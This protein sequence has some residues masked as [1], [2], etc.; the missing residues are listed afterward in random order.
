MPASGWLPSS[1]V[2][3]AKGFL[4]LQVQCPAWHQGR[5]L[6][7][8]S[9]MRGSR[10]SPPTRNSTGSSS[11]SSSSPRVSLSVQVSATTHCWVISI[12]ELSQFV[13]SP[14]TGSMDNN[15]CPARWP[16]PAA[17][18]A[19]HWQKKPLLVRQAIPGFKPLLLRPSCLR[20]RPR[21]AWSRAWCS[22]GQGLEVPARPVRAPGAAGL[23]DSPDWTLLV[24][25]VDLHDERV[26]RL[27]QQ[28]RF[29]PDARLDDV[30]ISYAS[31][32]GGVGPHFDSY[33][34]F[35]AAGP[36]PAALAH[37]SPE[38]PEPARTVCRSRSWRTS[39]PRKSMC[40]SPATCCTCR[41][42]WAH[43]GMAEGRV[44]DLL[45][46]FSVN[47]RVANWRVSC[48]CAWPKTRKMPLA[49]RCTAIRASRRSSRP[50]AFRPA[51]MDF[52]RDALQAVLNDPVELQRACS[53]ST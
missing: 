31:D 52:A 6:A 15:P 21:G 18:H 26:H 45:D 5:G 38:G 9:S 35:P 23:E 10:S 28:F 19:R 37:R 50:A 47:R 4:G 36:R 22:Q 51:C 27:M 32:G 1:T 34:V 17:I 42:R 41:P 39:S 12:G 53:V 43:D 25:G 29:V 44:H 20:W 30:M 13:N 16:D 8:P 24:Q 33:D 46:R 3:V 49:T 40:W 14:W 11:T 7:G 2:E 48:W